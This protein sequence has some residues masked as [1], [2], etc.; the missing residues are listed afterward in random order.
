MSK[1]QK[2]LPAPKHY[3]IKR[4]DYTYV[5][6]VK[7]SRSSENAVPAVVL[8]RE[9]LGY[10]DDEKEAKQIVEEG[11]ILRNGEALTDIQQGVGVLDNVELPEADEK[12]RIVR[13][14][15]YLQFVPVEDDRVVTK[16]T[17]KSAS[18]ESLVYRLHNGENYRTKDDYD[19]GSTL[20]FNSNVEEIELEEGQE[21]L[22]IDGKHAGETG[23]LEDI[24][25]EKRKSD[26]GVVEAEKE[27][28]TGLENLVAV[29]EDLKVTK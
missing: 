21:V 13:K 19:T 24:H 17:G 26:T 25:E 1:H 16:I 10:A 18:G 20:V 28:Q 14:G 11:G 27:F 6:S 8:L 5:A 29:T 4:K 23:K 12:Y 3:P 7:G 9:V 15:K 22:A 2:R